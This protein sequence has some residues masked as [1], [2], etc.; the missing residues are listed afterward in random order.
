ML[1]L[2]KRTEYGL[3]ALTHLAKRQGE[4]V[5]A[6]EIGEQF[7]VPK[8]LLAEVLKDL[9]LAGLVE[10]TRGARGGY[11]LT[12]SPESISLAEVVS[13][14]EGAP[15]VSGCSDLGMARRDGECDVQAVCPIRSPLHRLKDRIWSLLDSTTLGSIAGGGA[16]GPLTASAAHLDPQHR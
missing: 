13:A 9:G 14:L 5:P 10:S 2:T 6:R 16:T 12:R 7:P 1:K 15:Q 11:A 4:V 8:R 3:I